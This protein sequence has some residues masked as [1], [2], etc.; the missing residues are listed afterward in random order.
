MSE[1]YR[2]RRVFAAAVET[3]PGTAETLDATDGVFNVSNFELEPDFAM[4][5]RPGQGGTGRLSSIPGMLTGTATF[6]TDCYYNG[7]DIPEWAS[8]LFPACG[9][10]DNGSGV[11][12]PK[13]SSPTSGSGETKTL[14]VGRYISGKRRQLRGCMGTFQ[15]VWQSGQLAYI[16]WTLRG[17][18]DGEIDTALITPNYPNITPLRVS[19]GVCTYNSIAACMG[20]MTFNVNNTLTP[21]ECFNGTS[22]TTGV[23]YFLVSDRN[24]T[25]TINPRSRLVATQDRY[26]MWVSSTEAAFAASIAAPSSSTIALAVPKAQ[27]IGLT[28]GDKDAIA[29]DQI[30]LQ[31]NKNVDAENQEF[32]ISFT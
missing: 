32:S 10:V 29:I 30:E 27:I 3:T 6:R 13:L 23:D 22:N 20:Q 12:S 31:C 26:G 11:F 14:T 28:E 4:T 15:M 2:T 16:D 25:I 19:G 24:P 5:E 7:T 1:L 18:Y 8:I 17:V 9:L 21:L